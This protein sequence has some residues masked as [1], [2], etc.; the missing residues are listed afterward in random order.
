MNLIE[1][2]QSEM[3]RVREIIKEYDSIPNNAG[4]FAIYLMKDSIRNAEDCIA[5]GDT[6]GMI[7]SC[8]DLKQYE[9]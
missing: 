3:N 1:G 2:L 4:A 7:H 5:K 8:N 6:V 9:L